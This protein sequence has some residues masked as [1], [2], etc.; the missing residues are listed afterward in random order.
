MTFGGPQETEALLRDLQVALL[1]HRIAVGVE[2]RPLRRHRPLLLLVVP[3]AAI[4]AIIASVAATPTSATARLIVL[5]VTTLVVTTVAMPSAAALLETTAAALL[6]ALVEI[7]RIAS[8]L[9]GFDDTAPAGAAFLGR[10]GGWRWGG[11][12]GTGRPIARLRLRRG[13]LRVAFAHTLCRPERLEPRKRGEHKKAAGNSNL[14]KQL[15]EKNLCR[16]DKP[17]TGTE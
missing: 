1:E 8:A 7:L 15:R 3:A 6:A 14:G 5:L 9:S 4:P 17:R 2:L 11:T 12:A 13:R 10:H 16:T